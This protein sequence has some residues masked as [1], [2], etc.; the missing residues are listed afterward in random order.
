[1]KD[2]ENNWWEMRWVTEKH[3]YSGRDYKDKVTPLSTLEMENMSGGFE[4][5]EEVVNVVYS[6]YNL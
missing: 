5:K 2:F 4:N 1:M 6:G 3:A